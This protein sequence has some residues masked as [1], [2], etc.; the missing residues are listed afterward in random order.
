MKKLM[1]SGVITIPISPEIEALK[2]AEVIFP[3]AIETIT[4]DE[5]TVDGRLARKKRE[6]HVMKYGVPFAQP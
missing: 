5:D 6:S 4:T 1:S 2:M 3:L